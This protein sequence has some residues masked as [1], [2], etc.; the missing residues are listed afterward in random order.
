VADRTTVGNT[1]NPPMTRVNSYAAPGRG[2]GTASRSTGTEPVYGGY[3]LTETYEDNQNPEKVAKLYEEMV[4]FENL[5]GKEQVAQRAQAAVLECL[6]STLNTMEFLRNK[7][8]VLYRLWRGEITMASQGGS[9][10]SPTPFKIV[11][12]IH[13]RIMRTIFGSERWFQLYGVGEADDIAARAQEAICRDQFRV[14][15]Y[16]SKASRFVRDGL[17]YGTGIQKTYWKQEV[18]ER[19]YRKAR[20]VPNPETPGATKVELQEVKRKELMFDGNDCVN[21]PIFDFL[22]P[23][24]AN[25][26]DDAEWACDRS[27]WPDYKVKQMIELGHWTGLDALRDDPG[28]SDGNFADEFKERK[29][30]AYGVFDGAH[31]VQSPH[32]P[33]YQVIDWWGPLVISEGDNSYETR[34]CNVVMLQP[35]GRA[36]IARVTVNPYWHGKKPYQVW[37]PCDVTDELYGV[38]AIEM[39]AR[40]S[41][42]KDKKRTLLMNA[43]QLEGNPMWAV[44]DQ[45]NIPPGQMVAQP[46]LVVR[47]PDPKNSIVP[48]AFPGVSD[49]A[50]KAENILEAEMREVSGVTA[51]VIGVN[52]PMGGASKTATQSNNDL[53]E[54]N[55]RLS[56][57]ISNFDTEVTCPMLEQMSWNNMQFCSYEKV[58]RDVG[59]M[60]IRFRDRWTIRPEDLI[61]QFI[62][63]PLSGFRLMTKTTQVQQL[64]N[65]LDRGPIINQMYGPDAVK[66]PK[67]MA[68]VMEHGFDIRNADEFIGMPPEDTRLLTAIEEAELWYHGNVPPRRADDNDMRHILAHQEEMATERFA[69]LTM[70]DPGTAAGARA[71]LADHMRKVAL[72]Q[73]QQEKAIM[74]MAQQASMLGA[75]GGG[76]GGVEGAAEPGQE[77][78]SPK[79]RK[80][81]NER[82]GK[83]SEVKGEAM[84]NAPNEGAT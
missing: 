9:L 25:S 56:G 4:G 71:H 7:W 49:A 29:A 22:A 17:I 75:G 77:A 62:V 12:S 45:S 13:P 81:E 69:E 35:E 6:R 46:G 80:S 11:E 54:A 63:Q 19:A 5:A 31:A 72:E 66:M 79:V 32:V 40:L 74:K 43:T 3:D 8:L 44:S 37:R 61:G 16:R 70:R 48:L 73:E 68:Y 21:I 26:I 76:E 67:L 64:L 28:S 82:Q 41:R 27:L 58:V 39:I 18:Q 33:H 10:H 55:M 83:N 23:P 24:S 60:G 84:S 30:Y 47:C 51:P 15:K 57:A 1:T 52:D 20:R 42:E 65:M 2:M 38:G 14:M 53:D 34:M 59:A 78:D 50:L 36:L